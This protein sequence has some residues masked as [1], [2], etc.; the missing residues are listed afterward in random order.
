[1]RPYT[2]GYDRPLATRR[3]GVGGGFCLLPLV[4]RVPS[5]HAALATRC[6]VG[7]CPGLAPYQ[8]PWALVALALL[9]HIHPAATPPCLLTARGDPGT[10]AAP[11]PRPAPPSASAF[12]ALPPPVIITPPEP[13]PWCFHA[14][15]WG[16]PFFPGPTS[17]RSLDTDFADLASIPGLC[18]VGMAVRCCAA[19]VA[20]PLV[21]P[22]APS[23]RPLTT[24]A[25]VRR[26]TTAY[27]AGVLQPLQGI[28]WCKPAAIPFPLRA[29]TTARARFLALYPWLPPGWCAAMGA[30]IQ[31]PGGSVAAPAAPI[32]WAFL[33][34]RPLSSSSNLPF[35][36]CM[37]TIDHSQARRQAWHLPPRTPCCPASAPLCA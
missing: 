34:P 11:S 25:T 28:L 6:L 19:M 10:G 29:Y 36:P 8:P 22:P 20:V 18:T 35:K 16:N 32:G 21:L 13:G 1:P 14:P 9:R 27:H 24:A 15:P 30:V 37:S 31:A 12:S 7:A 23:S 17:G 3:G 5:W 26:L 33:V 4:E 2:P